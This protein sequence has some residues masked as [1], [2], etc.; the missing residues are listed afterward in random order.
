MSDLYEV[1][2]VA[3]FLVSADDE[4]CANEIAD[5]GLIELLERSD[6]DLEDVFDIKTEV[7]KIHICGDHTDYVEEDSDDGDD[8]DDDDSDSDDI[9]DIAEAIDKPA[10]NEK[11]KTHGN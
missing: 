5:E 10:R 3:R 7:T 2:Y 8:D 11:R 4:D 1:T 9:D 6:L